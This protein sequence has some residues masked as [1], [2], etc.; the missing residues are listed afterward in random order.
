MKTN[1]KITELLL[2]LQNTNIITEYQ[3]QMLLAGK[4]KEVKLSLLIKTSQ[5]VGAYARCLYGHHNRSLARGMLC[6]LWATQYLP[7]LVDMRRITQINM[8]LTDQYQS[9]KCPGLPQYMSSC[10]RPG[11]G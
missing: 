8:R 4:C 9:P 5:V 6:F 7:T 11:S 1:A 2:F 3:L 10:A